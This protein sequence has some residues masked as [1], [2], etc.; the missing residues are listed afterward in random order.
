MA[1]RRNSDD[2]D[3]PVPI[4]GNDDDDDDETVELDEPEVRYV[5]PRRVSAAERGDDNDEQVIPDRV[6]RIPLPPPWAHLRIYGWFDYPKEVAD[7]M[8]PVEGET[9]E[10]A[11]ERVMEVLR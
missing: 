6:L 10:E 1:R 5:R 7:R 9:A 8:S 4:N 11:S 2:D 3:L